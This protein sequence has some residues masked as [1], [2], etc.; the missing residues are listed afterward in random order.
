MTRVVKLPR[1]DIEPP[2][3]H[4]A[5]GLASNVFITVGKGRNFSRDSPRIRRFCPV[6]GVEFR[7]PS[8]RCSGRGFGTL[9]ITCSL[10]FRARPLHDPE[11]SLSLLPSKVPSRRLPARDQKGT[12]V[13]IR[14]YARSCKLRKRLHTLCHCPLGDGKACGGSESEDLP[15][16][17]G[18]N[19]R[20]VRAT[21]K[22]FLLFT[23]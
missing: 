19:P 17:T 15:C 2:E 11:L 1:P 14:D 21:P 18:R 7:Q 8:R 20:D 22:H 4:S 13:Q 5:H 10:K 12:P 3:L 16:Q 9:F 6:S 23:T